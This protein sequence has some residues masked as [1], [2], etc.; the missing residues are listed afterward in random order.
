MNLKRRGNRQKRKNEYYKVTSTFSTVWALDIP[1]NAPGKPSPNNSEKFQT[2]L[3]LGAV[4]TAIFKSLCKE[5]KYV[6]INSLSFAVSVDPIS[7]NVPYIT[8]SDKKSLLAIAAVQDTLKLEPF[9]MIWDADSK[10]ASADDFTPAWIPSEN[11]HKTV[12]IGGKK[13]AFFHLKVP[14]CLRRYYDAAFV[15]G[16]RNVGT[17]GT[18]FEQISSISDFRMCNKIAG[19]AGIMYRSLPVFVN[20]GSQ[21]TP[22]YVCPMKFYLRMNCYVNATFKSKI[23]NYAI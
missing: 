3:P 14:T 22:K 13:K 10:L 12:T 17:W 7:Y 11:S 19:T 20:Q 2:E 4:Q 6:K 23:M 16:K 8:G 18:F 5:Y 15:F 21:E 1:Y 9:F